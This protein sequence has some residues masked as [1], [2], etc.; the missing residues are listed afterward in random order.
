MVHDGG[1]S[2]NIY[3]LRLNVFYKVF[4]EVGYK[5]DTNFHLIG[6]GIPV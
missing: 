3:G 6:T 1:A 4:L 5:K 2:S